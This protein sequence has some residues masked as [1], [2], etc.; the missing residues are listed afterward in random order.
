MESFPSI[1]FNLQ[2][3]SEYLQHIF[4]GK[5]SFEEKDVVWTL[6]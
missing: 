4:L 6:E 2:V 5:T 1:Y 3:T